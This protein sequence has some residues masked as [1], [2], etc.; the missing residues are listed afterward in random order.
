MNF[1]IVGKITGIETIAIGNSIRI[2]HCLA[3]KIRERSLAKIERHCSGS[4]V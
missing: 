1:E 3:S 2:L 4:S